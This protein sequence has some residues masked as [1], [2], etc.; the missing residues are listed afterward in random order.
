MLFIAEESGHPV[1][2]VRLDCG[3][4][5]CELSW[6]VAPAFR[7]KGKGKELVAKASGLT[8][9]PLTARIL[10]KNEASMRIAKSAGFTLVKT[11]N[12]VTHWKKTK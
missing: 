6:T 5:D 2:T 9:L 3:D 10:E 11:E 8:D 7:G 4:R 12:G 1:G